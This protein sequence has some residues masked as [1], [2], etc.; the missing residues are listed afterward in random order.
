MN[1]NVVRYYTTVA[2]PEQEVDD[3]KRMSELDSTSFYGTP[4]DKHLS[5]ADN[6]DGGVLDDLLRTDL[7]KHWLA[8]AHH[9]AERR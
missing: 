2:T 9:H 5:N 6:E 7:Q 8:V 1:A 3:A 4:H